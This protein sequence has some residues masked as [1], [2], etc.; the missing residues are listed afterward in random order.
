METWLS[1]TYE[2][3]FSLVVL[4]G[5]STDGTREWLD[6]ASAHTERMNVRSNPQ[7]TVHMPGISHC[8]TSRW[9]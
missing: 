5:G 4:D 2:G 8:M 7:R 9:S 3:E 1:Q 6:E